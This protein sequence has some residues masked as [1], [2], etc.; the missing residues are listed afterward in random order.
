MYIGGLALH[1][2]PYVSILW[3]LHPHVPYSRT[4]APHPPYPRMTIPY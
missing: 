1:H 3:D 2:G 4:P